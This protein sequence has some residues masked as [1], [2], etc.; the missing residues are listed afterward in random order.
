MKNRK[1]W[2]S[3]T[4][5]LISLTVTGLASA[6]EEKIR[7][8]NPRGIQPAIQKIPMA[9]RSGSMDGKT[10]YIVDTKYPNTKPFVHK[11]QE[12]LAAKYPKTNWVNID[13]RGNYMEDDPQLW[14][15]IKEKAHGAIVL[16]GH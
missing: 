13:K 7:I 14:A 1:Q 15:E 12:N 10:I 6:A 8:L 9:V 5:I 4:I 3:W 16:I 11:L 2:L